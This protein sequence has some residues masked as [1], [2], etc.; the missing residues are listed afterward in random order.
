[1]P[2]N[3]PW[4]AQ[5]ASCFFCPFMSSQWIV[6][7]HSFNKKILL[8]QRHICLPVF[9]CI[10]D[11]AVSY[12]TMYGSLPRIAS[13]AT[14]K[15]FT[16][17]GCL[18]MCLDLVIF[19]VF[20]LF[21]WQPVTEIASFKAVCNVLKCVWTYCNTESLFTYLSYYLTTS[22]MSGYFCNSCRSYD[23]LNVVGLK[24]HVV[25][26]TQVFFFKRLVIYGISFSGNKVLCTDPF[27]SLC[28]FLLKLF[29]G[30]IQ[31]S[32][33]RKIVMS[34]TFGTSMVCHVRVTVQCAK[35]NT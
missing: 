8:V 24:S 7:E 6:C 25:S 32:V 17:A 31:C 23:P 34:A 27:Y 21:V 20:H 12:A 26:A 3:C 29:T 33:A 18:K 15:L 14:C 10:V 5:K 22:N 13:N 1:M 30:Q 28:C 35:T 19:L 16:G 4:Q 11:V 9:T 2:K